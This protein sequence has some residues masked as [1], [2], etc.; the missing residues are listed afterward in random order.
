MEMDACAAAY[1]GTPFGYAVISIATGWP[2][3]L[4]GLS[5]R[6]FGM[7]EQDGID[8]ARHLGLALQLTNI[9]RDIDDD[10]AICAPPLKELLQEAGIAPADLVQTL[11][12]PKIALACGELAS[13]AR[14][15]FG[16]AMTPS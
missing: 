15:H 14:T 8:L 4:A 10:A 1:P 16:D 5:V 7:Q 3:P 13:K 11:A 9:L 6:V 12:D 2:A